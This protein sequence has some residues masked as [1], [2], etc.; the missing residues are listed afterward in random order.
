MQYVRP[1]KRNSLT[2]RS[3]F[4]L[5]NTKS[6][7]FYLSLSGRIVKTS[8]AF[9]FYNSIIQLYLQ[10]TLSYRLGSTNGYHNISLTAAPSWDWA[11]FER[12]FPYLTPNHKDFAR[13]IPL[14]AY[15]S[16]WRY[17]RRISEFMQFYEF[18]L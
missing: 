6:L 16:M 14:S 17:H 4:N 18:L 7:C 8:T 15:R 9:L 11:S 5:S 13:D 3:I 10:T 12:A 2:K 1:H